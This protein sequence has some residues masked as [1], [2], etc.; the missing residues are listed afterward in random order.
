MNLNLTAKQSQQW[1]QLLSL[2]D[3]N[4]MALVA[5]MEASGKMAPTVLT[6]LQKR[7]LPR[8]GLS[9]DAD[10]LS[11]QTLGVLAVAQQSAS[12]A[13][14][15]AA[16]WQVVDAITT[17]GT[18]QQK[19]DYLETLQ[20]M[21]LPAMGAPATAAVTAMP[22]ADGWQL[23]GTVTHVI[24]AGMAQTY[25][26]LA[27]T[28]PD[29]P[30]A[31]LVRADQ[32]GVKVVNQLE[33]LGLRGLALAD[34]TLE[35]VKVTA[36]DRLGAIGQ[37]LAIFQRVQAV[38]QMMLSAVGAG[39]L[40]HAGR[41]I[42][43][44]ALMEQPPLA[45]L[46]PLLATARALTLGALSTAN[47]A[48]ENDA[49]FQSAAL[50]AW[51]TVSQSTP[52]LLSVTTLIGDLAYGVRSPMMALTQDLEMLPLLV[53]TAHHLATTFATHTLNAPAVEAATSEAH[54]EP[55][56]LA[57]SDLHRVV[58][59]LNLTKDVPVNVGSIAT[60]KRIVTLGRGAL[61]PAVLLQAQQLAKWIGAAIA[62]TQPLTSLEQ[63]SI[64][65]QIGGDAVSVAPEVL[66]NLGVSGDDQYL[67]GIVGARH[68]LSVN[69]DATAPIMAASHQVFVGDVTT[70]LDGMVAALN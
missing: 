52:Q 31:F 7:G 36:S 18:A 35:Q 9:A 17:Y 67:A 57:V 68:V 26:V 19:H 27:Q 32:P 58:K 63:F 43:Q 10:R 13:T 25:L 70:F 44:L 23:T 65:Q 51:Q 55:E 38:G 46:T 1:R 21:G 40:E 4:L 69:R 49:F 14:L 39:I 54:K 42:Q 20:L 59:K 34:L 66:I 64:D 45:E 29:V 28:P 53:G 47:Q 24:N 6:A 33:T 15:L 8:T 11:E 50:T 12:L 56:Q 3:D 60:A 2:M 5:D 22:V 48:D 41:Q 61:D 30:S 16:W 62:V 37:G